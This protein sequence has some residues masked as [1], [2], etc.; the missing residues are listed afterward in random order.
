MGKDSFE[1]G[2]V[3]FLQKKEDKILAGVEEDPIIT[4]VDNLLYSAIGSRASDIHLEPHKFGMRIRCR[5][6]GILYEKEPIS[7][8]HRFLVISR[9]KILSS[10][11][12]AESRLPQDGKFALSFIPEKKEKG[13]EDFIDLRISTF[14]SIYGEKMVVRILDRR[15]DCIKLSSLGFNSFVFEGVNAFFVKTQGFFLVCGPTGSG[16]TTTLYAILSKLNSSRCNVVTMED[17]VEYHIDGVT[18]S[19]VNLKSGFTFE[20]GMRSILRQD[21]DVIMV[22]EIRDKPTVQMAIEAALTGHLVL[23]SLH[24]NNAAGAIVRL[25]EMGVEPFLISASISGVLAQRLVRRLCDYC[26]SEVLLNEK[27]KNQLAKYKVH[28]GKVFKANGCPYCL[29]IG[30][31]GRAAIAELV[32]INDEIRKLINQRA[33]S[34]KIEKMAVQNGTIL[35]RD[36]L[37]SKLK[38]GIISLEEFLC[39]ID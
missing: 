36:D 23:S 6:D 12:I 4:L 26:K 10:L 30:Y 32:L 33:S 17:P 18:Q 8:A 22:G 34:T 1:S 28:L 38:A 35:L 2:F 7:F 11:D 20:N 5:I 3:Y 29:N 16:K 27:E 31:K 9:L 19:Q 24:T 37:I 21:P 39:M 13:S 15:R 25:I 14:P